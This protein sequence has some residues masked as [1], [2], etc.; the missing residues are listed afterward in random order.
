MTDDEL[1]FV[2]QE[3]QEQLEALAERADAAFEADDYARAKELFLKAFYLLPEPRYEWPQGGILLDGASLAKLLAGDGHGVLELLRDGLEAPVMNSPLI[4]LRIGQAFL[5][6]EDEDTAAN[7]LLFALLGGGRAVF[8]TED[9]VF[10]EF[11]TERIRPPEG[12][13]SW[14]EYVPP[15]QWPPDDVSEWFE[16]N[17]RE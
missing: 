6:G 2:P 9:P 17:L 4:N 13:A 3:I 5:I 1:Q 11:A 8:D 7:H 16:L 15:E 14:D 10:Y 12:C